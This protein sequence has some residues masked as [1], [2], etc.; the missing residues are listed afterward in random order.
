MAARTRSTARAGYESI[1]A[2]FEVIAGPFPDTSGCVPTPH[3]Q[4]FTNAPAYRIDSEYAAPFA[5]LS[6]LTFV[7]GQ[8]NDPSPAVGELYLHGDGD[9]YVVVRGVDLRK[10]LFQDVV[11]SDCSEPGVCDTERLPGPDNE[12]VGAEPAA[13]GYANEPFDSDRFGC[14]R[15]VHGFFAE[16]NRI[17]KKVREQTP[18][19]G[20]ERLLHLTNNCRE[21]GNYELALFSARHG[22][23]WKNHVSLDIGFYGQV[24]GDIAV[25]HE[26]LGTGLRVVGTERRGDGSYLYEEAAPKDFP[27]GC[28]ITNLA[29]YV[30]KAQRVLTTGLTPVALEFGPIPFA[31]FSGETNAK[32]GRAQD[33]SIVYVEVRPRR[34]GPSAWRS[35]GFHF[36]QADGGPVRRIAEEVDWRSLAAR[37]QPGSRIWAPHTFATFRDVQAHPFAISAF[38]VDGR[39]LGRL[40]AERLQ[41]D[42][43][44][45][46][47]FDYDWLDGLRRV[48]VREAIERDGAATGR[49]EFRLLNR[50]C[51]KPGKDCINLIVGNIALEPGEETSLVLGI[52][53][54]P[55]RDLY[56]NDVLQEAQQYALTYDEQRHITE[57]VGRY[58]L[59]LVVVRRSSAAPSEYTIDLVSYERAVPLWRG[60]ISVP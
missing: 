15:N 36:V 4:A 10:F 22:K 33:E 49:M 52:G 38:E 35:A 17:T 12:W 19:D 32:S 5:H 55:L 11:L 28:S 18:Q 9:G 34:P 1:G 47:S 7:S 42:A 3:S 24:L 23:L 30:G 60:I 37:V 59:G 51:G 39:Y 8:S 16:F 29:P 54:Q 27:A 31:D 13:E 2:R 6:R 58:G 50:R 53:T 20:D 45:L 43:A 25:A 40:K 26:E 14:I 41:T 44:R 46:Y 56:E 48:E 57:L 21:P